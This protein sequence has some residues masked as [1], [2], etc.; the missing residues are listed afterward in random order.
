MTEVILPN[1]NYQWQIKNNEIGEIKNTGLLNTKCQIGQTDLQVSDIQTINNTQRTV[2]HVIEPSKIA[3][4]IRECAEN[5]W[6]PEEPSFASHEKPFDDS[7]NLVVGRQY[8]IKLLLL[9]H[10]SNKLIIPPNLNVQFQLPGQYFKV[11]QQKYAEILVVP[12][13]TT[14]SLVV[15]A[16]IDYQK[17]DAAARSGCKY[18]TAFKTS[19]SMQIVNQV[20]I[21]KTVP[22]QVINIPNLDRQIVVLKSIGGYGRYQWYSRNSSIAIVSQEGVV[23]P[24]GVG[25]VQI[26]VQDITNNKNQDQISVRV[27]NVMGVQP[28]EMLKEA[29]ILTHDYLFTTAHNELN[30][31]FTNCSAITQTLKQTEYLTTVSTQNTPHHILVQNIQ[32][33][34]KDNVYIKELLQPYGISF[35]QESVYAPYI[36]FGDITQPELHSYFLGQNTY[37]VC[38]NITFKS[39]KQGQVTEPIITLNE[40]GIQEGEVFIKIYEQ[41]A[42]LQ[43]SNS[44]DLQEQL[45]NVYLT[46]G[47]SFEWQLKGGVEKWDSKRSLTTVYEYQD[48]NGKKLEKEH[49]TF[50]YDQ[51]RFTKS[52]LIQCNVDQPSP[53]QNAY[54][55]LI[56]VNNQADKYLPKPKQLAANISVTCSYP[57]SIYIFLLKNKEYEDQLLQNDIRKYDT[58]YLRNNQAY[59]FKVAAF[60]GQKVPFYNY[61]SLKFDWSVSDRSMAAL[62]EFPQISLF[63]KCSTCRD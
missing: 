9:D 57:E 44:F 3:L 25:E 30:Q 19:Q 26:V 52:Y 13:Q 33:E 24:K 27:S 42:T 62:A 40:G 61:S 53:R 16:S 63:K 54:K 58:E 49:I 20:K 4:Q 50:S 32:Q 5:C 41:F 47:S 43:P 48:Q 34:I 2:V 14:R 10:Q 31:K 51:S 45:L 60:T 11:I 6:D 22:N 37:G 36:D 35:D 15:D 59:E 55:V 12:K 56:Y 18:A 46:P 17:L 23:H 21:I 38:S 28:V 29:V 7:W 8:Y 39:F 1:F